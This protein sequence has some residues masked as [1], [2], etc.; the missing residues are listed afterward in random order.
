M[1]SF[2]VPRTMLIGR[3]QER[4]WIRRAICQERSPL[5]TLTG[6]GGVGKTRLA[7]AGA[8]DALRSFSDDVHWVDLEAIRDPVLIEPSV[9]MSFGITLP[10][11][12]PASETIAQA[13]RN[14]TCL[15]VLNN[16][17]HLIEACAGIVADLLVRCGGLHVLATSRAPLRI[18]AERVFPVNPL[19]PPAASSL[20]IERAQAVRPNFEIEI[21]DA[22]RRDISEVCDRLDNLPL[23]IELAAAR[24]RTRSPEML[25]AE[26]PNRLDWL[27]DGPRDL[28]DRQR[29]MRDTIAWSY[30]LLRPPEQ[31]L[32]R[33]L[34]VFAGAC[35]PPAIQRLCERVDGSTCDPMP[36]LTELVDQGLLY[37]TEFSS[38]PRFAMLESIRAF[39]IE[40]LTASNEAAV[41]EA[42]HAEHF[43]DLVEDLHP[44]RI[45]PLER[46][47]SRIQRLEIELPNVRSAL[48]WFE[49]H[50]DDL[51]LLRMTGALAVYWHARTHFQEARRW[52]ERAIAMSED[53]A[54]VHRARALTGLALILWAE[55]AYD[56]AAVMANRGLAI[57]ERFGDLEVIANAR[58]VLGMIEE[59]Q[60]HWE[61][62]R[63]HLVRVRD[64]WHALGASVEEAWAGTL[65]SRVALGQGDLPLA[66]QC[67]EDAAELFRAAGYPSGIAT[68]LSRLAEISRARGHDRNAAAA[69]HEAL[70][71]WF[72]AGE[73]W[74]ITLALG[75]L[76]DLAAMHGQPR[77]AASLVGFLD[78]LAREH[79]APLLSAARLSRDRAQ[80]VATIHLGEEIASEY[81]QSGQSMTLAAAVEQASAVSVPRVVQRRPAATGELTAR[82]REI[83]QLM[84]A[85]QTDQEIAE[86]LSLSRRT[87]SGHVAHILAKL[88]A[89][90]RRAAVARARALGLLVGPGA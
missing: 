32:F 2:P 88:D 89:P 86:L 21:D 60:D 84:A 28:P 64:E 1:S 4:A 18:R 65:L 45:D 68:A 23:A 48:D 66:V 72:D 50:G 61:D 73:R 9:A 82:E 59:I 55:G 13:L 90:N 5:I 35:A 79:G 20:F 34:S 16:C 7:I 6:P 49:R 12:R 25:L 8:G 85:M 29:T 27:G 37:Q 46:V 52:L 24:C 42:A 77:T 87:V 26:I 38:T 33:R 62:A 10:H 17:E 54:T 15:L 30:D 80:R 51:R 39:G 36:A 83:L 75:G 76:A 14:R 22:Q 69:F 40:Q 74:L 71:L 31:G 3:E 78:A 11:G 81:I 44:N 19:S 63:V 43:L 47:D 67:A 70:L 53:A 58:H 57:A 41:I 56:E